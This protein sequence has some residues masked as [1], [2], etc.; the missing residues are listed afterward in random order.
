MG[1]TDPALGQVTCRILEDWAF[2]LPERADDAPQRLELEAQRLH[3][4]VIFDG[5]LDGAVEVVTTPALIAEL[6]TNLLGPGDH[7]LDGEAVHDAIGELVNILG[8]HLLDVLWGD[9]A[10]FASLPQVRSSEAGQALNELDR[11]DVLGF[12]I[13]SEPLAIYIQSPVVA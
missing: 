1:E 3:A 6:L 4:R 5:A 11:G 12:M 8:A 7:L 13:G 10:S 9:Q 2:L